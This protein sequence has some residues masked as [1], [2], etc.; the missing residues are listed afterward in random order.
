MN[1]KWIGLVVVSACLLGCSSKGTFGMNWG[2]VDETRSGIEKVIA[3][4]DR[5]VALYAVIDSYVAK[6]GTLTDE[7]TVIRTDIVEKNR[8]Y[9]TTR[10]DLQKQYDELAEKLDDLLDLARD[11][12]EQLRTLCS[13][14]EWEEIFDHSDK[15]M[16]FKI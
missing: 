2:R 5:R 1:L 4:P 6:A 10:E 12:G 8:D 3:E 11:H 7:V 16:N 14:E 15:L 13:E 9:D